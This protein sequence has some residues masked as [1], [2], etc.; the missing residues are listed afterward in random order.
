MTDSAVKSNTIPE[1]ITTADKVSTRLGNL[2]FFDGMPS[3]K[4]V[5]LVYDNLDFLRGVEVFLNFV[6]AA[7]LEAMR[8]GLEELGLKECNDV[9]ILEDLLDSEP[10][11]LT[12]NTDTVY[13]SALLDL[14]KYGPIVVEVPP[15]CGP[16]TV[17]DAFFRFVVDMGIPGPDQGKGGKYLIIPPGYD[18][19]LPSGYHLARSRS[20]INWLILRGFLVDGKP[21]AA[22]ACFKK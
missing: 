9:M 1:Q 17:N 3:Q 4:T 13:C 16:G 12:G 11:F 5:D 20:Y 18:K 21:V 7:S 22:T 6:P 2:E 10:L 8:A 14:D 19:E 15:G